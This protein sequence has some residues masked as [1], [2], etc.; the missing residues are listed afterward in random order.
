[1][2]LKVETAPGSLRIRVSP[3]INWLILFSALLI[4]LII[5]GAGLMPAWARLGATIHN[6]G[7]IGGPILSLLILS[8]MAIVNIYAVVNMLFA[9]ELIVLDQTTLEIQKWL[10]SFSLSERSFPNCTIENLRYD[11]WS[12]GRSGLQNGIRFECAGETVTF[13]RQATNGDSWDLIDNMLEIYKFPMQEAAET[14]G[15]PAVTKW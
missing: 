7:S 13:A 10:F 1:M 3:R 11:E 12:G 5:A 6:G 2:T 14:E 15:S 9:S 4:L 8:A